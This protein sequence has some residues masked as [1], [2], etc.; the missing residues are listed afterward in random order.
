MF[1]RSSVRLQVDYV[2]AFFA[3]VLRNS[4]YGSQ[5]RLGDLRTLADST[6]EVTEDPQVKELAN[7]IARAD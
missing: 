2:A 3:E 5:V 4:P 7:L 1:A 6:Y